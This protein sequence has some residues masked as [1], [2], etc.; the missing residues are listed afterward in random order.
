LKKKDELPHQGEL[1]KSLSTWYNK[2]DVQFA[3][4]VGRSNKWYYDTIKLE[5]IGKKNVVKV[6][7]ALNIPE[8]YFEGF[9]KLPQQIPSVSEPPGEYITPMKILEDENRQLQKKYIDLFEKYT[10]LLEE[11]RQPV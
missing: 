3:K 5:R 8:N 6:C 7:R 4:A 11:I 1:L 2:G 10:K 9:Y